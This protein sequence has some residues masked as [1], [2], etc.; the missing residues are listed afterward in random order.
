M[1]FSTTSYVFSGI[2]ASTGG[3]GGYLFAKSEQVGK[4]DTSVKKVAKIAGIIFACA[5]ICG[6]TALGIC[7]IFQMK[8]AGYG[9][10]FAALLGLKVGL[11]FYIN[12]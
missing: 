5:A 9:L 1:F 6:I 2:C 7:T 4:N 11:N 10:L 12:S 8:G 3:V